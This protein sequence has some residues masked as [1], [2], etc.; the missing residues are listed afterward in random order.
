MYT[1]FQSGILWCCAKDMTIPYHIHD[2]KTHKI[3]TCHND[4][5]RMKRFL[6]PL[7]SDWNKFRL[8]F[9]SREVVVNND[10][11]STQDWVRSLLHQN[12]LMEREW[13]EE[14]CWSF[15][16][17]NYLVWSVLFLVE[18]KGGE[19]SLF[20]YVFPKNG[21]DLWF[22]ILFLSL[23]ICMSWLLMSFQIQHKTSLVV[24]WDCGRSYTPVCR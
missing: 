16:W 1:L 24:L 17:G 9:W 19:C 23:T 2:T 7:C 8:T 13:R 4:R 3:P 10:C 15:I 14:E 11:C 6:W 22:N 18:R 20:L 5:R 12:V 21:H